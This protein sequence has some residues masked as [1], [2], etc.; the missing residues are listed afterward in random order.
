MRKLGIY[1]ILAALACSLPLLSGR[2]KGTVKYFRHLRMYKIHDLD[3]TY[4]VNPEDYKKINCY[5][6][7]Y[8][9]LGRIVNAVFLKNGKQAMDIYNE[10]SNIEIEYL[11]NNE[12]W[13]YK[14]L[15]GKSTIYNV[16]LN[17]CA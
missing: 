5:K 14:D 2:D 17:V 6:V 16:E 15:R 4:P 9:T 12:K 3:F 10:L 13:Y 8:D 11:E 7:E 1:I